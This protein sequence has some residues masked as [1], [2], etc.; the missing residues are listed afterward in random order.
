M[1][2]KEKE[3]QLDP[4]DHQVQEVKEDLQGPKVLLDHGVSLDQTVQ[5]DYLV[6]LVK[7]VKEVLLDNLVHLEKEV[8]LGLKDPPDQPDLQVQKD[9]EVQ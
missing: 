4:Q 9:Q 3:G 8:Q 6:Q 7:K 2:S 5:L 1:E